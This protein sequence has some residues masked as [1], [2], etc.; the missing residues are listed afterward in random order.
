MVVVVGIDVSKATLDVSVSEGPVLSF[1]NSATG[2]RRLL[3]HLER[4]GVTT[5]VCES[6]GGYERLVVGKL[7]EKSV[8]VQVAHPVRVRAFARVCGYEAKTDPVDAQILSRYGVVFSESDAEQPEVDPDREEL[9]QLL[10]RRRQ[11]VEERVRERNRLDKGVSASV[12][13]SIRRNIRWLDREIERLDEE[14]KEL[15][16]HNASFS[17]TVELYQSVPG[18]G[19]LTAAT[20]IA[21]LPELGKRDGKSLTSLVGLAPWSRDSGQK[22]GIRSI[23]GGRGTVRRAL[24]ICAWV[25]L[26]LDGDLRDFYRRLR[27]RGKPGKVATIA[28]ARKLLMQLNAVARRGTPWV[29]QHSNNRV[30]YQADPA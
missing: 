27:E 14:Y 17:E 8:T 3:R 25:V 1:E 29:K 26:R 18:V 10:S 7:R 15:L 21:Y 23:R 16:K 22:R 12:G 28:V 4:A 24:Y 6:T 2:I 19:Q 30:P 13:K 11:L 9:R 20:L 5:A